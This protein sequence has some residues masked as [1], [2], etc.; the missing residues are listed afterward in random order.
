MLLRLLNGNSLETYDM[1]HR[2]GFVSPLQIPPS[3]QVV[4]RPGARHKDLVASSA[5]RY[6]LQF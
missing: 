4:V 5:N 6:E 1:R 2:K 3:Q